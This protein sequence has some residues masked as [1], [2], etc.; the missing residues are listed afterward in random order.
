M[1]TKITE[2]E[3]KHSISCLSMHPIHLM[4][5][6]CFMLPPSQEVIGSMHEEI[7]KAPLPIIHYGLDLWTCKTSGRKHLG[8]HIFY[9]DSNFTM[10]H[11]LIA[12]S[13]VQQAR[14]HGMKL[15]PFRW[16]GGYQK[17]TASERSWLQESSYDVLLFHA[18]HQRVRPSACRCL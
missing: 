12:V 9:V 10:R 13:E 3:D 1:E 4:A 15:Y 17:G 16:C 2:S 8:V 18:P 6:P 11:A 14:Y 5:V 7:K